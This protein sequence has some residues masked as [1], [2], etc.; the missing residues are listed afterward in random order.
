MATVE[1]LLS[2]E[3][4]VCLAHE[5]L[6]EPWGRS[7]RY[8]MSRLAQRNRVLYVGPPL[9]L[10]EAATDL[11][12]R[13]NRPPILEQV[14]P[15]LLVYREPRLFAAANTRR[16]GARQLN[17]A[18]SWLRLAH[19]RWLARRCGFRAPI[20]WIYDPMM[21]PAAGAFG[22]KLVVYHVLDN[23]VEFFDSSA[24]AMR[25]AMARSESRMLRRADIVFAVSE[26]L[27]K[28]CL[29]VNPNSF[30]VPNGVDYDLFLRPSAGTPSD[31]AGIPS[32]VIGHIGAIQGDLDFSLLQQMSSERPAWSLVF[33]GPDGL[34]VERRAFE[35]LLSRPNVYYLG[36]KQAGEVPAYLRCCDVCI[37]P[38]QAKSATVPDSDSVKLYEYLASGRPVVSVDVPAVRRFLPLVRIAHDPA[39]FIRH[40]EDSLTED[41]RWSEFRR[42]AAREHSW[43]RRVERMSELV[44]SRL[45]RETRG[46]R[47]GVLAAAR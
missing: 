32:P 33:V 15:K 47:R 25:A 31:M 5:P 21:A 14:G 44:V 19:A 37:M 23:Y 20:L 34:G 3:D 35:A 36:C 26:A 38:Y 41:T 42:E 46:R 9:T 40:V 45:S 10:R 8:V 24:P 12:S 39:G 16:A 13:K 29:R 4:I 27:H 7:T 1:S 6:H 43:E 2:N 22:E 17:E 30:L 11:L 18:M 28:R